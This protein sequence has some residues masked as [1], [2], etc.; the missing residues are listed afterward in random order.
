MPISS[1][2]WGREEMITHARDLSYYTLKEMETSIER[3]QK[4]WN[5]KLPVFD[6]LYLLNIIEYGD[7]QRYYKRT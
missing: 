3:A 4:L 6:K 1:D 7:L 2:D 5:K